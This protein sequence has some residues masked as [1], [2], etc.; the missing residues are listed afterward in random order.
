MRLAEMSWP[1]VAACDRTLPVIIPVAAVEQ[2][3]EHLPLWTDSLLLGEIVER[4]ERRLGDRL[5]VLPLMWLG[6][7]HHHLDFPGTLSADPRL[8][9]DLLSGLID[10]MVSHGFV[11]LVLLNGHGGNDVPARQVVFERR[12]HYRQRTDL[13][14]LSATY[15]Q[16]AGPPLENLA[17]WQ[18]TEMGHADEW[19]T[20]M[21]MRLA[22][23]SVAATDS[24]TPVSQADPFLPGYV[25]WITQDRTELGH[26]GRPAAATAEKGE[27]LLEWFSGGVEAWLRRLFADQLA[28]I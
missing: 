8:Y 6:N 4:V 20:S 21:V 9:L 28:E 3:S 26:I 10:N 27:I 1:Q 12:Q 5:L 17:D 11:H 19:E 14:L 15:W 25:G 22:P 23:Q 7:S 16:I 18:Q 2:H 24:L 13:R